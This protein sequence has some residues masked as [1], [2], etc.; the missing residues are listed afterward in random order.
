MYIDVCLQDVAAHLDRLISSGVLATD[1][2]TENVAAE[3]MNLPGN[4]MA[5]ISNDVGNIF[6][7]FHCANFASEGIFLLF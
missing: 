3:V 1:D 7:L 6:S 4:L 2:I 5:E